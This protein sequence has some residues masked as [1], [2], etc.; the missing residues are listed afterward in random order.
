MAPHE[1]WPQC[2]DGR[3]VAKAAEVP[4][5]F[6]RRMRLFRFLDITDIRLRLHAEHQSA[7]RIGA[8]TRI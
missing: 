6:L 4:P 1:G 2:A 3:Y 8:V 5:G 7:A